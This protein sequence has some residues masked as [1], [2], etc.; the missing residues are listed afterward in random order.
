VRTGRD[1]RE[2]LLGHPV[3]G[4]TWEGFAIDNLLRVAPERTIASF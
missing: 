1:D 2:A 4:A 3:V